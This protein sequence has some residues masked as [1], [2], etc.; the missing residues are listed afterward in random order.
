LNTSLKS[1][2]APLNKKQS[3]GFTIQVI[4]PWQMRFL[5]QR[6]AKSQACKFTQTHRNTISIGLIKEAANENNYSKE[7]NLRTEC[8]CICDFCS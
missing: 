6:K 1:R 2:T 3:L 5:T 8:S 7:K 4:L